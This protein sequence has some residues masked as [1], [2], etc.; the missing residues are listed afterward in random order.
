MLHRSHL[1]GKTIKIQDLS[2]DTTILDLAKMMNSTNK[3]DINT[4]LVSDKDIVQYLQDISEEIKDLEKLPFS[5]MI[6]IVD[7]QYDITSN[8]IREMTTMNDLKGLRNL[9]NH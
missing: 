8:H 3:I 9:L 4:E 1:F 6:N 5:E 7:Q 2:V